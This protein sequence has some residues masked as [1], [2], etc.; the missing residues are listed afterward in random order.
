MHTISTTINSRA[1]SSVLQQSPNLPRQVMS[2]REISELTGKRHP[3]VKRDI[4][5]MLR[6]LKVDVSSFAHIYQD[7]QR[8][9]QTEY[10]LD[11]EHTDCLLTGYSAPMRMK[12]IRRWHELESKVVAHFAIPTS[13]AQAL[14]VAA[15]QVE[16]NQQLQ[17]VIDLQAPK[18]AAIQRL[19]GACGAICITDA[20]KHLQVQPAKLFS[21][22]QQNK[23]IFHRGGSTRWTAF[24]PRISQGLMVHKVTALRPDAETGSERAAF[25]PLITLKGLVLLAEKNIGAAL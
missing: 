16:K 17:G 9:N 13:F 1:D 15:E 7:S 24:Q 12:V 4:H 6:D 23:W 25:Q 3:D 5:S 8:R 14:R 10:L 20:A 22:L 19:A 21:W 2:S 18:V 11:R